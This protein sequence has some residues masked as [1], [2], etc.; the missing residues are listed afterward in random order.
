ME[1]PISLDINPNET[2]FSLK[3]GI[4][5]ILNVEPVRQVLSYNNRILHS[6]N[7]L[8]FYNITD[9]YII[10]LSFYEPSTF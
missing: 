7:T 4:E 2:I 9:G 8:K 6:D 5:R 10:N 3:R 1:E